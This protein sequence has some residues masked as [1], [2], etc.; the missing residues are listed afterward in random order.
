MNRKCPPANAL[1]AKS[2]VMR[3]LMTSVMS[4][5]SQARGVLLGRFTPFC[6]GANLHPIKKLKTY[7]YLN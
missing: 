2:T 1:I 4:C 7:G 3:V 6:L 5:E